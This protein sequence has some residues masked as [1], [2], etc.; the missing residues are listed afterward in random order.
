[1]RRVLFVAVLASLSAATITTRGEPVARIADPI[2]LEPVIHFRSPDPPLRGTRGGEIWWRANV[3]LPRH[4][5]LD[6]VKVLGYDPVFLNFKDG[7]CFKIQLDGNFKTLTKAQVSQAECPPERTVDSPW[8]VPRPRPGVG[9]IGRSWDL[10]AWFDKRT[11]KTALTRANHQ[12]R[13]PVLTADMRVIG[14]GAM[15]A[16]DAPM[17][18]VTLVGYVGRQLTLAT[19]MLFYGD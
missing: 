9:Y 7:R 16:P 18:E 15:G 1:M 5:S 19:V 11:G 10:D 4:A 8:P 2:S 12:D 17:T 13:P 14:F 3:D 6:G